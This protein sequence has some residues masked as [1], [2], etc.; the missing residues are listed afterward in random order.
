MSEHENEGQGIL[1]GN[2][3][4]GRIV[5]NPATF[6]VK[7]LRQTSALRTPVPIFVLSCVSVGAVPLAD[8]PSP[9]PP[10]RVL[11]EA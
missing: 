9:V 4:L 11:V 1:E 2:W 10:T 5:G 6:F 3:R 7:M 8:P